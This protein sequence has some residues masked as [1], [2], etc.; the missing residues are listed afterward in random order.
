MPT[1]KYVLLRI[2]LKL[3]KDSNISQK[4]RAKIM[5]DLIHKYDNELNN[6]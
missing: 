2:L 3:C 5:R 6:E 1:L 4:D